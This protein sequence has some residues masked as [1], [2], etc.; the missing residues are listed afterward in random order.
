MTVGV[1]VRANDDVDL[2]TLME[3]IQV[4]CRSDDPQDRFDIEDWQAR[5]LEAEDS[6]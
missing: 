5:S 4:S 3:H 6:K 1:V 2:E